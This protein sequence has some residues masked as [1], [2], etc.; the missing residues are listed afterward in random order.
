MKPILLLF[1]AAAASCAQAQSYWQQE[2]NYTINVKLDDVKHELNADASIEYINNS[3]NQLTFLYFHLW[4]NAYKNNQTA[5]AKQLLENG[6]TK[7]HYAKDEDRGYIDGLDFKVNGQAVKMEYDPVH[8]DIC[9]LIL[10]EP[11]NPGGKITI[12]TPFHVKIPLGEFSRLGHIRQQYQI[13]QWYPKPAVYDMNGWNQMPYLDQGEF[14]S[15][16]GSFDVSITVP[17]NYV[18]MATGDIQDGE[19]EYQ[20]LTD[21]ANEIKNRDWNKTIEKVVN[22][23]LTYVPFYNDSFPASDPEMKTL[24]FKQSNVHDFAWFCD[25]R[26]NVQKSEVELPVSKRKV[27]TWALFTNS[28]AKLWTKA[29]EYLNDAIFY[30]SKWNG[31]YPYNHCTAVDGAL[32][33]GGGME[34]PNITVIGHMGSP[35]LLETV[36]MHEVGHNWFYGILGSNER[37]HPWMDEG[38]NSAN[39]NRYIET[40]YPDAKLIGEAA[41]SPIGQMFDIG[42]Y[43]HKA[44]Y[45]LSYI[46][47]AK[48]NLDQPIEFPSEEYT[49]LNYGGIVYSKTA[50]AFDYLMAYLGEELYDKCMHNYFDQWKFKHP[51]PADL[52]KVFEETTGKKLDW[53]FNDMINTTKKLDYRIVSY[54]KNTGDVTVKNAGGIAGPFCISGIKNGKPVATKWFEG[55]EE[56]QTV[57]LGTGDY[58]QVRIDPMGDMPEIN[59]NNNILKTSGLLKKAEPLKLQFIGS[60]DNPERSQVFWSPVMGWNNYN[61]FMIGAAFYNSLIP[62]KTFDYMLMPMYAFGNKDLAGAAELGFNFHPNGIFQTI[63][64]SA[65]VKRYAY[66]DMD[67]AYVR[68][69]SFNKFTPRL[70]F[71]FRK[72]ELRSEFT[73]AVGVRSVWI[74]RDYF[75]PKTGFDNLLL[76]ATDTLNVNEASYTLSNAHTIHPFDLSLTYQQSEYFSKMMV[77]GKF[78]YNFKKRGRKMSLRL[79]FGTFLD[80]THALAGNYSFRMSGANGSQDY[81]YD[82][83][84]L[85]RSEVVGLLSRQ[86]TEADG[87]FKAYANIGD[88]K[89]WLFAMN[90][91]SSLPLPLVNIFADAGMASGGNFQYDAGLY[92]SLARGIC[93][94]YFPLLYSQDIKN[95]MDTYDVGFSESIRFTLNLHLVKPFDALRNFSL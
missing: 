82:Y 35:F 30:Y 20:W 3:P 46:V 64:L 11:L 47:N 6:E 52:R 56:K 89:D 41:N 27:T 77:E 67:Q 54:D 93:E 86:F 50:I 4:P 18:L 61:K 14:Y 43:Y 44:Q 74:I 92:L 60:L 62:E 72:R 63:R 90:F 68:D 29:T 13:T 66:A 65:D 34:Y 70:T 8:I 51:Q 76:P 36:I 87:G 39:E 80:T 22:G 7:L 83:I 33:A 78:N 26:Y 32:S 88:T 17:K 9:K 55:F 1:L 95:Y 49:M 10:N 81:L 71:E 25:K 84:Y 37:V 5:L 21:K 91:K 19:A 73:H 85:G 79:F 16:W 69:L 28:E 58:D 2:V 40:K 15:E 38:I 31:E 75:R 42:Q 94:V 57:S 59:R 12:T 45:E 23:K 24:R 53:F 48:R